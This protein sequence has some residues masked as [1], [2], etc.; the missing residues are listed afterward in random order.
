MKKHPKHV[1]EQIRFE[2][3]GETGKAVVYLNFMTYV[4][5]T[6]VQCFPQLLL[7]FPENMN[8]MIVFQ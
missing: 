1:S 6:H 5:M 7:G 4:I 3:V 2:T 8:S